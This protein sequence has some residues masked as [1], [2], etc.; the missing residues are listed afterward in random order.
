MDVVQTWLLVGVPGVVLAA[1]LF[2]GRSRLRAW[3]GY[4]VL[5]AL[6]LTF[7]LVPGDGVSAAV[8]GLIAVAMVATGRGTGRDA[9]HA[10][11]HEQRGRFTTAAQG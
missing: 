9:E 11:H 3:F 4:G 8:I 7:V 10:E 6:V 2:V 5:L 1:G